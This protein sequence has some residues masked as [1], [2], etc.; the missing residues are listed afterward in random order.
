[1]RV[2]AAEEG[3]AEAKQT[4]NPPATSESHRCN[5]TRVGG[6]PPPACPTL[7]GKDSVSGSV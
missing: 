1:M 4:T 3:E 2:E 7:P 5:Y 6:D